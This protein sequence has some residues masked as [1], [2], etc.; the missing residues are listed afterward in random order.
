[1]DSRLLGETTCG[2]FLLL[3]ANYD[4]HASRSPT[5]AGGLFAVSKK[6]FEYLGSYDIGME[7]W[8]GENLEFSFRVSM[9]FCSHL[10]LTRFCRPLG[11]VALVG[12]PGGLPLY[13]GSLSNNPKRTQW[14]RHPVNTLKIHVL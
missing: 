3:T 5:M 8:G 13:F 6:Y 2:D 10:F 14:H 4:S 11:T 9:V 1:M 12:E 7:V